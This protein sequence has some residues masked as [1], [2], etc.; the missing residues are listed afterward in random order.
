[1]SAPVLLDADV[2]PAVARALQRAGY[3]VVAASGDASLEAL[4]DSQLLEVATRQHRVLVTF[5]VADFTELAR[6]CAGAAQ[7]HGGIVL[8]HSGSFRRT[9]IGPIADA[10]DRL[11]K[12]RSSFTN[13]VLYLAR[14]AS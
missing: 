2:P 14:P 13:A 7:D 3:D 6:T 5:N 4:A 12:F 1:V 9:E 10:L 8:I 11:L